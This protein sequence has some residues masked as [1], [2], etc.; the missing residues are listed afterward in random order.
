[1]TAADLPPLP[2]PELIRYQGPDSPTRPAHV[3]V[4]VFPSGVGV[5][6]VE[7]QRDHA[8]SFGVFTTGAGAPHPHLPGVLSTKRR[9]TGLDNEE[10]GPP[11]A[12][13][14]HHIPLPGVTDDSKAL[15]GRRL[16]AW[17]E[18]VRTAAPAELLP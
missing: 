2:L 10:T 9:L 4:W 14:W 6:L 18:R 17:L 1:M 15:F 3:I 12:P 16:A 5:S 8:W 13:Y 7:N 11:F